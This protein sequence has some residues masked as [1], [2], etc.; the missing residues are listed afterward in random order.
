MCI[1]NRFKNIKIPVWGHV[2]KL[3]LS[4]GLQSKKFVDN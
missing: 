3:L 1:D 2:R 4:D